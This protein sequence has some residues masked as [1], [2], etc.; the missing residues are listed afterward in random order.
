MGRKRH[1]I[2]LDV[3]F[4]NRRM[5]EL[6]REKSGATRF[7]YDREWLD[8]E[9][10]LPVSLSLPLREDAYSGA[11]VLAV[12]DN[13]LPDY[14]PIRRRV[15]ER[16]GAAGTD[17]YSLL[18]VIGRDCIGALQF[19]PAGQTPDPTSRLDGRVLSEQDLSQLLNSLDVAPLGLRS[20]IDFRISI[21][22]AQE[23]TA[24]LFHD[25]QW[26]EPHGTTPTSHI[27]KP[28]IG[29]LANGM[30]LS[31]SVENE[32]V[33]LELLKAFGFATAS[34][35]MAEFNG[36]KVLI[37]TRFDRLWVDD[38]RLVRLPQEDCCQALGVPPTLKYQNEGGP[39]IVEIM[40]VLQGSDD[41]GKDRTDFFKCQI[42]FWLLGAT[43]G[44]AK[45]F[46][47]ALSSQ[48]RFRMTPLY[49]V[50]SLQPSYDSKHLSRKDFRLAMRVGKSRQYTIERIVGRHFLDSGLQSG[51][52]REAVARIFRETQSQAEAAMDTVYQGLPENFP[53]PLLDSICAGIRRR[54]PLLELP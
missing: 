2:P 44:H 51:L 37:V 10:A 8:W 29:R 31:D 24:L 30:D 22:G 28:A 39:G 52:S 34:T 48:G 1:H 20:D 4:N 32:F 12:F 45:N 38:S 36:S 7:L 15:A 50:I 6:A 14:D 13:L 17:A 43:D 5:G 23:K 21:A 11:A 16:V 33:C 18:S 40:N 47:L 27:L 54:L 53:R 35:R 3:F 19:L 9:H 41:P 42:L 49:D 26:L 25:D 46:S